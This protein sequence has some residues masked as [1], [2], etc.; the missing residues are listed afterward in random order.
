MERDGNAGSTWRGHFRRVLSEVWIQK[1]SITEEV[2]WSGI[3]FLSSW[4]SKAHNPVGE[5]TKETTESDPVLQKGRRNGVLEK[6]E[7]RASSL[8][9]RPPS[10]PGLFQCTLSP[11]SQLYPVDITRYPRGEYGRGAGRLPEAMAHTRRDRR[12][13]I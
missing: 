6:R 11:E 3:K 12:C 1:K 4:S 5:K 8:C 13:S 9:Y 2:N 10:S 7:K